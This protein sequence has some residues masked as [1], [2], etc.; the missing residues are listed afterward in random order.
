MPDPDEP[1]RV[2]PVSS[3][4]IAAAVWSCKPG[5]TKSIG[6]AFTAAFEPT[7]LAGLEEDVEEFF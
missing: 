1:R 7:G 5:T 3:Y 6:N 4:T 2:W